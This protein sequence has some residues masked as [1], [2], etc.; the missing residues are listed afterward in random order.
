LKLRALHQQTHPT[1]T[2]GSNIRQGSYALGII[3]VITDGAQ[4]IT[5]I[6]QTRYYELSLSL[7]QLA[8]DELS[9]EC[10]KALKIFNSFVGSSV[11]I[12]LIPSPHDPNPTS[13]DPVKG[14]DNVIPPDVI[15]S[16]KGFA[17]FQVVKMGFLV[18][19]RAGSG[20]VIARLSDGSES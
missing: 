13:S 1:A 5:G 2:A 7:A 11:S 19:A 4:P 20:L 8:S 3:I 10:N 15:R 14:V 12:Q 6:T 17:I 18:S 16:A 9:S